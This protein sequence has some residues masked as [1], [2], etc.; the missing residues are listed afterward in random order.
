[1]VRSFGPFLLSLASIIVVISPRDIP[2][3]LTLFPDRLPDAPQVLSAKFTRIVSVVVGYEVELIITF[4]PELRHEVHDIYRNAKDTGAP[5]HIFGIEVS[6]A[7]DKTGPK[8][9]VPVKIQKVS[10]DGGSGELRVA[11]TR[12]LSYPTI[13]G[14]V[15][16]RF[17]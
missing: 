13:L 3:V 12:G 11:P 5:M 17:D 9:Q 2:D 1:M 16:Q 6:A 7:D 10:W 15:A 14:V 4:A 8:D